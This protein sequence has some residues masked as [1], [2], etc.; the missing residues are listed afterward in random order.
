MLLVC[1]AVQAQTVIILPGSR[2]QDNR[3]EDMRALLERN[4]IRAIV[5]NS[6]QEGRRQT[7]DTRI[8]IVGFSQGGREAVNSSGY[9]AYVGFYPQCYRITPKPNTLLI[10]GTLDDYGEATSCPKL[11]TQQIAYPN[12]HHSFD[13]KKETRTY[14]DHGRPIRAEY[15]ESATE[16]AYARTVKWFKEHL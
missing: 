11:N 10:Y 7:N 5:A 12:A 14:M 2:G 1:G 9:K 6:E 3:T 16:D 15:N 8:G 13:R 4:G